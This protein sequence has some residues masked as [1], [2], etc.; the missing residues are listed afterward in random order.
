MT[1]I[2]SKPIPNSD[3]E[4]SFLVEGIKENMEKDRMQILLNNNTLENKILGVY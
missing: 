3:F 4:Y 2:E 1:K